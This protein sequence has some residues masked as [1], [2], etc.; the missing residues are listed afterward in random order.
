MVS[1]NVD[2]L[3]HHAQIEI[4]VANLGFAA[5]VALYLIGVWFCHDR[6]VA[7]KPAQSLLL[8]GVAVAA[9]VL[10]LLPHAILTIGLLIVLTVIYR[11]LSPSHQ[12]QVAERKETS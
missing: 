9:L 3:T 10:G 4:G 12:K 8:P 11:Q 6:V 2:V 1:V 7:D 5:A